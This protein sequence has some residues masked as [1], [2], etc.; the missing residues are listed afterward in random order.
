MFVKAL[1]VE[2]DFGLGY[3]WIGT[4]LQALDKTEEAIMQYQYLRH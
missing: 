4:A 2:K 3:Y 1:E